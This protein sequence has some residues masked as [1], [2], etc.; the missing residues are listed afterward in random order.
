MLE[1]PVLLHL[2]SIH[3]KILTAE[4][5][6]A[7]AYMFVRTVATSWHTCDFDVIYYVLG[8]LFCHYNLQLLVWMLFISCGNSCEAT[9][10]ICNFFIE[11]CLNNKKFSERYESLKNKTQQ[12]ASCLQPTW[13]KKYHT[14]IRTNF[15]LVARNILLLWYKLWSDLFFWTHWYSTI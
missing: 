8:V 11:E 4:F 1:N 9:F 5:K 13:N 15:F 7:C 14:L 3:Y 2:N 12:S 10:S 6:N